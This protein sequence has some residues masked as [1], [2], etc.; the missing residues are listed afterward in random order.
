MYVAQFDGSSHRL[1]LSN[2]GQNLRHWLCSRQ[3]LRKGYDIDGRVLCLQV[4]NSTDPLIRR[5]RGNQKRQEMLC[6]YT[7]LHAVTDDRCS[8]VA[9]KVG[10]VEWTAETLI[11]TPADSITKI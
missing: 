2:G 10:L 9:Q 5:D 11:R 6:N 4:G 7:D 3:L 8:F 1:S